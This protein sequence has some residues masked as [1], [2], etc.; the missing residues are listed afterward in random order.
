MAAVYMVGNMDTE[1][2]KA[3]WWKDYGTLWKEVAA[4]VNVQSWADVMAEEADNA[5]GQ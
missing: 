5:I 1:E 4:D 2:D 3:A